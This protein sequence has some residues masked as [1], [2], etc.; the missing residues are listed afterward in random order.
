MYHYTCKW[1]ILKGSCNSFP[2]LGS[3]SWGSSSS[4]TVAHEK[5]KLPMSVNKTQTHTYVCTLWLQPAAASC[6]PSTS[7]AFVA[8][9]VLWDVKVLADLIIN[10]LNPVI[11]EDSQGC[12]VQYFSQRTDFFPCI[13]Q[14]WECPPPWLFHCLLLWINLIVRSFSDLV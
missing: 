14:I 5:Y 3:A 1:K 6:A 11:G 10:S 9:A 4:L 2:T 8:V 12:L 7:R 13:V